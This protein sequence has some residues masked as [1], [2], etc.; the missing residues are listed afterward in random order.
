M[1]VISN[2]ALLEHLKIHLWNFVTFPILP[3]DKSIPSVLSSIQGKYDQVSRYNS[4]LGKFEHYAGNSTYNQFSAFE[5]CK[6][7]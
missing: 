1:N 2:N 5:F 6:N 4:Q 7:L 3:D